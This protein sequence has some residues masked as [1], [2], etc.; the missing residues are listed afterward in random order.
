MIFL[1][2]NHC[3]ALLSEIKEIGEKK[4]MED[5]VLLAIA[6]GNRQPIIP[7]MEF[8]YPDSDIHEDLYQLIQYSCGEVCTSE[9]LDNV[10]K[11]WTTFVEPMLGVPSRPQGAEDTED[12]IKAANCTAQTGALT[13]GESDGSPV[14]GS[15]FITTEESNP[16]KNVGGSIPPEQLS[17]CR[18]W[19]AN[20]DNG[21][22]ADEP[23]DLDHSSRSDTLCNTPLLGNVQSNS[24]V[25]DERLGLIRQ[26]SSNNQLANSNTSP[27]AGVDESCGRANTENTS[28]LLFV[29]NPVRVYG[30]FH[31]FALWTFPVIL[32]VAFLLN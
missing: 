29:S 4:S 7:H 13:I 8:E 26:V 16:S 12:I 27:A 19:L 17:S 10:M 2:S 31:P 11:I 24:V 28:G 30:L 6:V 5:D 22:K 15:T 9:Q 3:T 14:C 32:L 25:D 23:R 1:I 21:V 20:G 18:V